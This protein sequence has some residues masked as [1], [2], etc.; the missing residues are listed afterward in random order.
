MALVSRPSEEFASKEQH[1]HQD[2]QDHREPR[3]RE[4]RSPVPAPE[5]RL[6]SLPAVAALRRLADPVVVVAIG[7][8]L[9]GNAPLEPPSRAAP[10]PLPPEVG[11]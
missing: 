2:Q 6:R 5:L 8:I 9:H 11:A 3:A 4:A 7:H 1:E 10:W